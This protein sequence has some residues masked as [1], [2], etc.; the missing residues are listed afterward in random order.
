M[1]IFIYTC[2]CTYET[3]S[4]LYPVCGYHLS[5]TIDHSLNSYMIHHILV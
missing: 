4:T 2:T 5:T 3:I 1:Y